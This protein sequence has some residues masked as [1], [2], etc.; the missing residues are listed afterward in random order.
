MTNE[1]SPGKPFD[2]PRLALSLASLS[3]AGFSSVLFAQTLWLAAPSRFDFAS[4]NVLGVHPRQTLLLAIA[5]GIV[6][7]LFGAVAALWFH[8]TRPRLLGALHQ[9]AA[10]CAP[11]VVAFLLPGLF[12]YQVAESKPLFYL[13]VLLAFGLAFNALLAQAIA[14]S[15]K[16]GIGARLQRLASHSAFRSLPFVV[17]LAGAAGYAIVLGRYAVLHQRLIQTVGV[18]LG[19][20]DNV[21]SNLMHGHFFRAP[22]QF[23]TAAGNYLSQHAEYASVLFLPFYRLRPAAE[24]LLWLQVLLAALAVVPLYSLVAGRLGRGM[25]L[26]FGAAYLLWAPLHGALLVGFSWQPAVTL[27]VFTLYYA[28]DGNRRYLG[29]VAAL[30]LLSISEVGAL[31]VFALGLHYIVSKRARLGLG[32]SVLAA[33]MIAFNVRWALHGPGATENPE[34]VSAMRALTSNPAYFVLDLAR[35]VKLTSVMHALAPLC[36]LPLFELASWPLFIPALLLTSAGSTFWPGE[37]VSYP[38]SLV[39]L[40]ACFLG[41]LIALQRQRDERPKRSIYWAWVVTLSLTQLCHS[42]DFGGLLRE[43]G[44][45]GQT[46]PNNFRMTASGQKRYE[47]LMALVRRIPPSASV[48][49]TNFLLSHVSNRPDAYDLSRP[50]GAPDFILLSSREVGGIRPSLLASF[51]KHEYRLVGSGFDEF[52]LFARGP[53]TP[54]TTRAL[55]LLGLETP[56]KS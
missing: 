29:S 22:A 3:L 51:A 39:W 26:W 4:R 5:G 9:V 43:D 16:W 23:G 36:F 46:A 37:V 42:F 28:V 12:L 30:V 50:Y 35:A 10:F 17:L 2:M 47:Q 15:P 56:T 38:S 48:A 44:F 45:G 27:L 41:L 40:P 53:E 24:T 54:E 52:Y 7:P 25:A 1:E 18:E 19:I 34:L 11:L 32:L 20:A 13:T 6:L 21:M 33:A 8:L 55:S 14:V 49:T 31:Y